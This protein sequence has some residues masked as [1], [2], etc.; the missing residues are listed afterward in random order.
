MKLYLV[1]F[2]C[3]KPHFFHLLSHEKLQIL[4]LYVHM[5]EYVKE[6]SKETGLFLLKKLLS[7]Q[8]NKAGNLKHY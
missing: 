5:D 7:S 1:K 4:T 8:I 2:V 6:R 3:M